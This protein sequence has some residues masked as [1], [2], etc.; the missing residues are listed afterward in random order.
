M[1]ASTNFPNPPV[2]PRFDLSQEVRLAVVM[3]GGVSLT[4]YISGVSQEL[5]NLVRATSEAGTDPATGIPVGLFGDAL[6]GTQQVYRKLGQVLARGDKPM[7]A[8]ALTAGSPIRTRF[9]ID[10]LSGSSAGG[11]NA[12]FL[13]KGLANDQSIQ[14]LPKLWIDHADIDVLLNDR[15]PQNRKPSSLLDSRYMYGR[16]LAALEEMDSDGSEQDES[17]V[18][19]HVSELDLYIT[20]TDIQ[21]IP[22]PLRLADK[23][24]Y[25]MRHKKVFQFVYKKAEP[26]DQPRND[27]TRDYNPFLAFAARCTSAFP[28]AFEPETLADIDE[29]TP[30]GTRRGRSDDE[31]WDAFL[32]EYLRREGNVS[33]RDPDPRKS[34][35]RRAFG[36]GGYLDNKPFSYAIDSL[37]QR[38]ADVPLERKL[39]Y[40]EPAP[41]HPEHLPMTPRDVDVIQNVRAAVLDLPRQET[42]REDLRRV[43][44]R[45]QLIE[46][47]LHFISGIEED[48]SRKHPKELPEP[49][50]WNTWGAKDL[51][52]MIARKGVSFGGYHRL[53][54]AVLMDEI[55]TAIALA[56][57]LE[58]DSDYALALRY[59][60]NA[61]R[62]AQYVRYRGDPPDM[63]RKTENNLL[64]DF[65]LNYRLRR[66]LFLRG[67]LDSFL[68]VD[69]DTLDLI[70]TLMRWHEGSLEQGWGEP[71]LVRLCGAAREVDSAAGL[72]R[73]DPDTADRL[74]IRVWVEAVSK[75]RKRREEISTPYPDLA[76]RCEAPTLDDLRATYRAARDNAPPVG[77]T[78]ESEETPVG[79]TDESEKKDEGPMKSLREEGDKRRRESDP[80][81]LQEAAWQ[82]LLAGLGTPGWPATPGA[83]EFR[84]GSRAELRALRGELDDVLGIL[85]RLQ[86]DFWE[87][88]RIASKTAADGQ[89]DRTDRFRRQVQLA[90]DAGL[91]ADALKKLLERATEDDRRSA[92]ANLVAGMAGPFQAVAGF[93]GE[94]V[95]TV[96]FEAARGCWEKLNASAPPRSPDETP[97]VQVG[98]LV[99]RACAR[100]YYDYYDEYDLVLFPILY[101]T[102]VGEIA[103]VDIFR[104]SPE[105]S[106]RARESP[107]LAGTALANFGAFFDAAWRAND[108]LWGR[109]DGA[110]RLIEVLLPGSSNDDLRNAL[111][112]E[113][114]VAILRETLRPADRDELRGKLAEALVQASAGRSPDD[115]LAR[116]VRERKK[117]RSLNA[118]LEAVLRLY[119]KDRDLRAYI[120]DDLEVDRSFDPQKTL[121]L[122]ARS[123][124][125]VGGMLD[126][127]AKRYRMNEKSVAWVARVGRLFWGLVEVAIPRSTWNLLTRY[128]LDLLLLLEVLM[129]VGGTLLLSPAVQQFALVALSVTIGFRL[130]IVVLGEYMEGHRKFL[131]L[132]KFFVVLALAGLAT[133]GIFQG[134]EIAAGLSKSG[135]VWLERFTP[136]ARLVICAFAMAIVF[137]AIRLGSYFKKEDNLPHR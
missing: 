50:A 115:V 102:D 29:P 9:R 10:I 113:A 33:P 68:N 48:L 82:V 15:E 58:P 114:Q 69:A 65:D 25:E 21:G 105:D 63:S 26:G 93:F 90:R 83:S 117:S 44:G 38:R 66:L 53:K 79:H 5:F 7:D 57:D 92:A 37:L 12:I 133:L 75:L 31:R 126:E 84:D 122:L 98:R 136:F 120:L 54:M 96:T 76:E 19:P 14:K 42:I 16:L 43:L 20:A 6:S 41:E 103:K 36:D 35:L 74:T 3:Y 124:R 13:A 95:S 52:E 55:A 135:Q 129:L 4:C 109:L 67:K 87:P 1:P 64:V 125:I 77:Q 88:R 80:Y 73:R 59:L 116:M 101:Q 11:I 72:I 2:A 106:R 70:K 40:I 112:A 104:I 99:A 111:L 127:L 30:P 34:V 62:E 134:L 108:I 17:F 86:R 137:G 49:A 51:T 47:V 18:S 23:L 22:L 78:E 121:Q 131:G 100:H 61:W 32:E 46:R 56:A 132:V 28:F 8:T 123:T 118:K 128:F 130:G 110:Q 107:K 24:V 97:A 119:L 71:S 39:L 60:V 27:F 94:E 89:A 85:R 45:N 91:T 81:R